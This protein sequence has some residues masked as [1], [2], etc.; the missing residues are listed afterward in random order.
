MAFSEEVGIDLGT[1]NVIV[2]IKDKGIVLQ[3]P[4]V[5]AVNE[6]TNEILAVGEEAH[7]M[8]GRTPANIVALRP[9]RD[10]VISN[11][12]IT[13]RMLKYFIRKT[14]GAGKFF[15][16]RIMIC[17]PSGVTEVEKRAAREAATQAGGKDVFLMEEPLAAA[18]GAGLD[19]ARP[20]GNMVM[21]IGGGTTDIAIIALGG[22]VTS[23]SVK[24]A[25]DKFDEAIVKY[26]RKKH[27]LYIGER[28]AEELKINIGTAFPREKE[29]SMTCSGRDLV[30]GL[31]RDVEMTSSEMMEALEEPLHQI[32]EASHAVLEKA[33]PELAADI[34]SSGI[35]VTGG[36]ALM[37]GID[38]RVK[39]RT[40]IDVHIAE[41]PMNC[42]A[43]G[44]GKALDNID[45]IQRAAINKKKR[46]FI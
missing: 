14:C 19:V 31:P 21:D 12:D 9:L 16:P 38:Q 35:Y 1:A 45:V 36:G 26:M 7:Q 24:T 10:G 32:C 6:E 2:Y 28:T 41:E 40:G 43:I 39:E 8:L 27:K 46:S 23:M 11:Y 5:V 44:T 33:P 25:G 42:V 34:S 30:T 13:E 3:E 17:V 37:Y 29:I 22:I 4:S 15:R 18:I 20:E